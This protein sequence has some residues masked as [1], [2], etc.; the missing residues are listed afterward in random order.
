MYSIGLQLTV[1]TH[2]I[3]ARV[4]CPMMGSMAWNTAQIPPC[5]P[6]PHIDK[7]KHVAGAVLWQTWVIQPILCSC[8]N[9]GVQNKSPHQRHHHAAV[10]AFSSI[11]W[12]WFKLIWRAQEKTPSPRRE[13]AA[14]GHLCFADPQNCNWVPAV[15]NS[16]FLFVSTGLLAETKVAIVVI[17]ASN[18]YRQLLKMSIQ[19]CS[20]GAKDRKSTKWY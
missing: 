8:Y 20:R 1:K 4:F 7:S 3:I 18:Q 11:V 5:A 15:P 19:F 2:H 13:T 16:E 17:Q 6:C 10:A 9:V 14:T 12:V